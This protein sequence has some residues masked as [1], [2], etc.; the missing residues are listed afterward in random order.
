MLRVNDTGRPRRGAPDAG[1]A[2]EG[3]RIGAWNSNPSSGSPPT[4]S[5]SPANA[6]SSSR[7][8]GRSTWSR[9]SS[10]SS[11][12]SCS[13]LDPGDPRAR[14]AWRPAR[15]RRATSSALE[16]P[17]EPLWRAGRLSIGYAEERDLVLLEIEELVER[18]RGR[19]TR[20]RTRSAPEPRRT[21]DRNPTHPTVG[22]A[23]TDARAL[24][25]RR[26]GGL[27]RPSDV[28]V[29]RQPD[30]P[31][32]AHVPGDERAPGDRWPV[33]SGERR[34][35]RAPRRAARRAA[36]RRR[37]ALRSS[38]GQLEILG[39]LPRSS[40][41][42]FLARVRDGDP[43]ARRLQAAPGE[44]PCGT[45]PTGRSPR[46]RSPRSSSPRRWA[47]RGSRRPC[48]A[49]GPQGPGSVQRFVAFDPEPA[50]PHDAARREPTS[51]GGSPRSTSSPTTPTASRGTACSP[52]TAGSSSS[53]TACASTWSPSSGR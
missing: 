40:N 13:A 14:S 1:R 32:G 25:A 16:E 6:S 15:V 27:A 12:W 36:P 3:E 8:A 4:R 18:G 30:R 44:A 5:A 53:I 28:P 42:T 2:G 46:A 51:S 43:D 34:G 47:G 23:R 22:H 49:T 10:R 45:S 31:R 41:Y 35:P 29:L 7:R 24:P 19:R 33:I 37:G 26:G 38:N 17:I 50:L 20:S 11:R 52:R 9:S 21:K 48:C 39:L